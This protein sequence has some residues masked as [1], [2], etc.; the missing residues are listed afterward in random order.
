MKWITSG[1]NK[2][3]RGDFYLQCFTEKIRDSDADLV[4]WGLKEAGRVNLPPKP[5]EEFPLSIQ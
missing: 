3:N 4:A 2:F 5:Q 1:K